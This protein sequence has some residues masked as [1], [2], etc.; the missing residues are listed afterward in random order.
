M[1]Y[2]SRLDN[3]MFKNI[4]SRLR[5]SLFN[6]LMPVLTHLGGT[7]ASVLIAVTLFIVTYGIDDLGKNSVYA[8]AGSQLVVQLVKRVVP[9]PRPFLVIKDANVWQNLILRDYSFPSGH[10]T[11][12]FALAT[13]I[14]FAHPIAALIVIPAAMLIG[15]S[16][17][18]LGL[19]YPTD[20]VIGAIIGIVSAIIVWW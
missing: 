6:R 1:Y 19:H 16:R 11:A 18:Y 7:T 12:S 2:I 5:C 13:V 14:S 9:R 10:T 3:W 17:I 8:L 4:N 15:M 20:V